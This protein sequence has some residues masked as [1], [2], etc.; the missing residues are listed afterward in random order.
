MS[1]PLTGGIGLSL[2]LAAHAVGWPVAAGGTG[3]ISDALAAVITDHGGEIVTGHEVK[4]LGELPPAKATLLDVTPR[5]LVALAGDKLGWKGWRLR[6]W[7]YGPAVCKVDYLLSGPVPWTNADCQR[8]GVV[9]LGGRFEDV[10]AAEAATSRGVMAERPFVLASQPVL[11]DP[12]RAPSGRHVLWAYCHVPQG[13]T[14]DES[15]RLERQLDRFAPGWRDLVVERIVRTAGDFEAYNPNNVD[16][17][18]AGGSL[19]RRGS[20]S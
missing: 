19:G 10:A 5:Q 4:A 14:A 9:H 1:H 2:G 20:S 15:G 11:A 18:I 6:A 17:D 3:A 8:A 7:R 16:G 13:H 12:E